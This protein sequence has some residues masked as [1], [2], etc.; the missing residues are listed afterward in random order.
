M[1]KNIL[2]LILI[3]LIICCLFFCFAECCGE[4][5][6]ELCDKLC[7][8]FSSKNKS[9][10]INTANMPNNSIDT[11]TTNNILQN[12]KQC[13]LTSTSNNFTTIEI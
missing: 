2:L 11:N 13:D 4:C 10:D 8:T 1:D 12:N 7:Y 5:C 3:I 9:I 6:D